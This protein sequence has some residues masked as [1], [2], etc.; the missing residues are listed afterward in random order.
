M[1]SST[2]FS[3][4]LCA[5]LESSYWWQKS[6]TNHVKFWSASFRSLKALDAVFFHLLYAVCVPALRND[7]LQAYLTLTAQKLRVTKAVLHANSN[8]Q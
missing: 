4:L 7:A 2:V 3:T 5:T 6:T 1:L 8:L